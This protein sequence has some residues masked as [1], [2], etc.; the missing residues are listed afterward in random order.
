MSEKPPEEIE[1]ER[2]REEATGDMLAR[3]VGWLAEATGDALRGD[4][5]TFADGASGASQAI[6]QFVDQLPSVE[7]PAQADTTPAAPDNSPVIRPR[8]SAPGDWPDPSV[9]PAP[10]DA[11]PLPVDEHGHVHNPF[12]DELPESMHPHYGSE[13]MT[14]QQMAEQMREAMR[15]AE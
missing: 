3:G 13:G 6:S 12:E 10:A 14:P 11:E 9:G 2:L 15:E 4:M 8:I 7:S 5:S 1:A